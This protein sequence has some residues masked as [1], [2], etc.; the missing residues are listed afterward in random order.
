M[1]N[2]LQ[3]LRTN[4]HLFVFLILQSISLFALVRFNTYHQ[5]VFFST[6]STVNGNILTSRKNVINYFQLKSEN[7]KLK[8]ENILLRTRSTENFIFISTDTGV[9]KDSNQVL[10]Y[11]YIPAKVIYNNIR[12]EKNYFTMDRGTKHGVT[13]DMGVI[14]PLGVAGVVVDVS[15]NFC[16]AMSIL[17]TNFVLTPKINGRTH[18]GQVNWNGKNFANVQVKKISDQYD[19]K[20]GQE[21]T[22]TEYGHY[23]PEHIKIGNIISAEKNGEDKYLEIDVELATDMSQLSEVYIIKNHFG[24]ELKTL[25]SPHIDAN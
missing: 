25:E 23:F 5:S 12:K 2:L 8:E 15:E 17:N 1:Q 10:Q 20:V 9:V 4:F 6:A 3:F 11:S 24:E 21:V 19:I 7:Q 14:S 18:S 16:I 13:Q 22:T